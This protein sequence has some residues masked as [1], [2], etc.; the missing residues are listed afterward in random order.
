MNSLRFCFCLL[1]PLHI[2]A[3]DSSLSV[4][5][6]EAEAVNNYYNFPGLKPALYNGPQHYGYSPLVKGFAYY[7]TNEWTTGS[8]LYDGLL[9][10]NM[11]LMYDAY[12][13]KL[14]V[15]HIY[16]VSFSPLS[17]K[18][19]RFTLGNDVFVRLDKSS[20][21]PDTRFY[22]LSVD[23][24]A[25]LYVSRIKIL[26]EKI[27]DNSVEQSFISKD[28]FYILKESK[29]QHISS[30]S[31]LLDVLKDKRREVLQHIK[32]GNVKFRH[33]PNKVIS[34]AVRYYNEISQ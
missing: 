26:L 30:Q 10:R 17:D 4:T 19:Q 29:F 5:N 2:I 18:I 21:A 33:D 22:Q 34:S 24:A 6:G 1:F 11:P 32:S 14:V 7:S 23:G 27:V 20:G 12:A 15:K 13:D 16:G 31:D 28:R 3:Q 9:Y 8:V 25:Q